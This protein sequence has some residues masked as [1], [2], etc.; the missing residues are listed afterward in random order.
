MTLT[1]GRGD[2]VALLLE[3]IALFGVGKSSS[4]PV[5]WYI[6]SKSLEGGEVYL[7]PSPL[8]NAS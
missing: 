6:T 7:A 5:T 2:R 4:Y 1:E 8:N 3:A